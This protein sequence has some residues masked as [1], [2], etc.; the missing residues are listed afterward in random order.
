VT[1]HLC[2]D[3]PVI[4][5][6]HADRRLQ[7]RFEISDLDLIRVEIVDAIG[8]RFYRHRARNYFEVFARHTGRVYPVAVNRRKVIVMTAFDRSDQPIAA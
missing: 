6:K 1:A 4:F 8:S 2:P 5:T 3:W 7:E